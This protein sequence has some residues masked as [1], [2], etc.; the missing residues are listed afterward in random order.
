MRPTFPTQ[1]VIR[2]RFRSALRSATP[3]QWLAGSTW[4][5]DA[6]K[7]VA[8][9][10]ARQGVSVSTAAGVVAAISPGL[11]WERN[12]YHAERIIDAA[13]S[14]ESKVEPGV[15]TYSRANVNKAFAIARGS[16]PREVL[17]GPKVTAFYVLLR[18]G[19]S[20]DVVCVDGHMGM[21][22]RGIREQVRSDS[23]NVSPAQ[24]R[25]IVAALRAEG[26]RAGLQPCQAQ[27]IAWL[28]QKG[29]ETR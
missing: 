21:M 18:D 1:P 6:H 28:V 2:R 16:D 11:R 15:P 25:E 20:D 26:E 23:G 17:S 10:A 8:E 22:A 5:A 13:L 29:R 14:G 3:E 4:Y 9:L 27:A 19:G 24:Y 12:V 7:Q